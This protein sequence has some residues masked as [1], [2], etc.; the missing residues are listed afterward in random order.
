MQKQQTT[1]TVLRLSVEETDSLALGVNLI[2]KSESDNFV[3]FKGDDNGVP[4]FRVCR[5][6]CKHQGGTFIKD[7]EDLDSSVV[8]CTKH[9]WKLD[10]ETMQYVNPPDSFKQD[11]LVGELD[12]N[13]R[14]V[15]S[16]LKPP[17][18]WQRD[19]RQKEPLR[20]GEVKV[21]YLTHASVEIDFD[22]LRMITDPWLTGPA[23]ARGWWL[24]HEPPADWLDR[25]ASADLIY[26]SHSHS[27]H[28]SYP[29][30]QVLQTKNPDIP[31]YVGNTSTPVFC[32]SDQ[33]GVHM[34]DINVLEFGVW[35]E[36]NKNLRFM[37]LMDGVHPELDTCIL[38]DYKG[39]LILDTVD[40]TNP[41]CGILPENVDLMMSDFAGGASGFPMTFYAGRYTEEWKENYI[42]R[43]RRK[44]LYYKTQVVRQVNPRVY[45]PF[46]GYFV[47]AHPSDRYLRSINTKNDPNTLNDL[48]RR[49][50]PHIQTWTP[51]PGATLD[52]EKVLRS[53]S[54]S[55]AIK[56]PPEGI[57]IYK[58]LWDF[59]NYIKSIDENVDNEIFSY[60]EWVEYYYKWCGFRSYNLVVRM[61][62]TDDLFQPIEGG[63]DYYVDFSGETPTFPQHPPDETKNYLEIKNRIGVHRETI[64]HGM[65]WDN[66]YIGFNNRISRTP[67]VF[68]YKFWNHMQILLPLD[69]PDWQKFLD[70]QRNKNAPKRT[71]WKPSHRSLI[72]GAQQSFTSIIPARSDKHPSVL[73][74]LS[75]P[76]AVGLVALFISGV[77]RYFNTGDVQR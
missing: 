12:D 45:L 1:V 6:R 55:S 35:K 61:I 21:T 19:S 18:P 31:I 59:D 44:L 64:V 17:Q 69:P 5:N 60:P 52:L 28:L 13:G 70:E 3:V 62:E 65:F 15:L 57:K 29:T 9:G 71:K 22:G 73:L 38:I 75:I 46:A 47:E 74:S 40:C 50:S 72:S 63:Y 58:D 48:I 41:N 76:F 43:E 23:F 11:E 66:L 2:N 32:K 53:G 39:H 77:I 36:I 4:V 14:L 54:I 26:I 20:P 10:S 67:D 27:D 34:T 33:H 51:L 25:L 24:L 56:N 49:Y 37:I 7:I 8:R 68:H 16:E 30:L 42:K